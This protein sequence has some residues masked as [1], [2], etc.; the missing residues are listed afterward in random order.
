[1]ELIP[2]IGALCWW[3]YTRDDML[4]CRIAQCGGDFVVLR[5]LAATSEQVLRSRYGVGEHVNLRYDPNI[6]EAVAI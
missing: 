3:K 1:M 2:K 4:L 5:V 6:F